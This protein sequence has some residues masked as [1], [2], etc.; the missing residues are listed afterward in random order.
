MHYIAIRRICAYCL[1]AVFFLTLLICSCSKDT[2]VEGRPD[3]RTAQAFAGIWSLQARVVDGKEVPVQERFIKLVLNQDGTF[4]ALYRG[5]KTQ[6]WIVAGQGGYSFT[7]PSLVLY[8][9]SGQ[10]L[11]LLVVRAEP[12][13]LQ[14]HHGSALVPLKDQEPD[15]VFVRDTAPKGPTRTPSSSIS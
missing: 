6:K 7:P 2:S 8:W 10:V 14:L 3:E 12:N 15:D 9:D 13:R 11:S 5:E 4:R 1:F